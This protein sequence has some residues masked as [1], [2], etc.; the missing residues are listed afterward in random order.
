MNKL[1]LEKRAQLL[2]MMVEGVSLRAITRL[3]GVSRT[4]TMKLLE[5]AGAACSAYQDK[6]FRNL[7]TKRCQVD[8]IWSFV[9]AKQK[10]VPEELKGQL[11]YGDVWTWTAIDADTKLVPSW[12]VGFRDAEHCHAFLV[13][14]ARRMSGRIQLTSDGLRAYRDAVGDAFMGD[15]DYATLIKIY[16]D[17]PQREARY[18]QPE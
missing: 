1:P 16:G 4:T 10:N 7:S 3:T 12:F 18:S 5:D 17:H 6:A 15:V 8:E 14:L 2:G 11:G 13:D 9:Y